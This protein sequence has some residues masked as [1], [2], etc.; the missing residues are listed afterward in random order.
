MGSTA[1]PGAQGNQTGCGLKDAVHLIFFHHHVCPRTKNGKIEL[2][3]VEVCQ[4][5]TAKEDHPI[6]LPAA[7]LGN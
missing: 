6:R 1:E 4:F 3:C 7:L 5:V 2:T